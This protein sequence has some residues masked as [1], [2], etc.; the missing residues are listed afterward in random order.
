[1]LKWI[2]HTKGIQGLP[3][4]PARDLSQV[5]VMQHGGEEKLLATGLYAKSAERVVEEVVIENIERDLKKSKDD[6]A[7]MFDYPVNDLDKGI[8]DDE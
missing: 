1:M 5:E 8:A 7:A 3:G 4:I 2:G 6:P